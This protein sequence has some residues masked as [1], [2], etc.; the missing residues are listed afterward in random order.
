[1]ATLNRKVLVDDTLILTSANLR[2][3]YRNSWLGYLWVILGPLTTFAAQAY[4]FNFIF[5][6]EINNYLQFLL[7]GTVPWLFFAQSLEM[8]VGI[9][10][11]NSQVF[12][13]LPVHPFSFV[14]SQV[15]DNLL[16]SF[17]SIVL[18]LALISF[19][20][21]VNWIMVIY[22]P[23]P[24]VILGILTTSLAFLFSGLQ[25]IFHDLRFVL[26]FVLGLMFYLM[27]IIYPEKFV[28]KEVSAI[29]QYNP[30]V[31]VFRPYKDLLVN[32]EGD[33]LSNCLTALF[34]SL[35]F[36]GLSIWFWYKK[37]DSIYVRF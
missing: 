12:K 9:L 33:F 17:F 5:K 24:Y 4:V 36:A 6:F 28:P 22:L 37:R 29:L 18:L 25:V 26:S 16:N 10:Q 35:V 19:F 34:V 3:R 1:M 32:A 21:P 7:L 2:T 13:S 31:Y 14:A 20:E 23:I 15:L 8:S 30:L 27:P 11:H